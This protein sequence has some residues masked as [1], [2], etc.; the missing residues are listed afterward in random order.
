MS[1]DIARARRCSAASGPSASPAC[2]R[3]CP[4]AGI[5]RPTR[6]TR[7]R[8]DIDTL[9]APP[10]RS[11][12]PRRGE[13]RMP[14][15]TYR[16]ENAHRF[17][18]VHTMHSVPER[19]VCP[20]C[21]QDARRRPAAPHLS[22]AGSSAY[23]LIDAASRSAHEPDVVTSLPGAPRRPGGGITRNPLHAKLPR[24]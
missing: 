18:E 10:L 12:V 2:R 21:G 11:A 15:Y 22:A 20:E 5:D 8:E 6:R 19:S 24:H 7:V 13:A 3:S 1:G 17:D 14:T 16:C 23:D 4:H 9:V